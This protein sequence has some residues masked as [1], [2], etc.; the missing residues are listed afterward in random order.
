MNKNPTIR[1]IYIS[2]MFASCLGV[3]VTLLA[4]FGKEGY[5]LFWL[6]PLSYVLFLSIGQSAFYQVPQNIGVTVLIF[7]QFI[8]LVLSPILVVSSGYIEVITYNSSSNMPLACML[9]LMESFAITI[10]LASKIDIKVKKTYGID[11][12]KCNQKMTMLMILI[13]IITAVVCR[14]APEILRNYRTILGVF[15]DAEYSNVEQAYI[16]NQY[17]SGFFKKLMLVLA[18]YILKVLRILLPTFIMV[19]LYIKSG[20]Y[21]RPLAMILVFSPFILVDGAI[22]RSIYFT[23]FLL[24]IYNHLFGIDIKKLYIPIALGGIFVIIYFIFRYKLSGGNSTLLEYFAEKSVDYFAG[25][26]IVAGSQNLPRDISTRLHYLLGEFIRTIPFCNTLFG[27]DSAD[28]VQFFFN[29]YN[30][31]AGGQIPTTIGMS[32]YYLSILFAPA[33]SFWFARMTK[34]YGIK[35]NET[36]NPYYKL[37]YLYI[38]FI[39]AL[40]IGM[41]NIEITLGTIV[42]VIFPIFIIT[43]LAYPL[44]REE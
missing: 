37:V 25:A 7:I 21:S 44:S 1:I 15:T 28:T 33:F 26:N 9:M 18:N 38:S 27:L 6:L 17:A 14:F 4:S 24:I 36:D 40:G 23:L 3:I 41:Y 13:V 19:W 8:R 5:I 29:K 31:T 43:R 42:Q 34:K 30:M 2:M 35:M 12:K 32:S 39:S 22:A 11:N 20:K 10:A 16:V